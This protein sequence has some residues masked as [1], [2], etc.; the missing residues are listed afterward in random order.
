VLEESWNQFLPL[1]SAV[2]SQFL[3]RS[4]TESQKAELIPVQ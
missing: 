3:A 2:V 1:K 4:T